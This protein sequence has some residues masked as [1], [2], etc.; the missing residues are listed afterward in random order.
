MFWLSGTALTI[1]ILII[2]TQG[3]LEVVGIP[4]RRLPSFL[5]SQ[6]AMTL[7]VNLYCTG[8]FQTPFHGM[9]ACGSI[10]K[11]N[12]LNSG[13]IVYRIYMTDK[14]S[15]A[16]AVKYLDSTSSSKHPTPS[17]PHQR[18]QLQRVMRIL[19]ESALA[20]TMISI[21]DFACALSKSNGAFITSA[22]VRGSLTIFIRAFNLTSRVLYAT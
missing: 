14:I 21:A 4:N 2:R 13:F 7:A 8:E 12:T 19:T 6:C 22:I 20:Y 11:A 16:N 1:Y 3:A 15:Q 18:T 17:P 10:G 9:Q 5:S